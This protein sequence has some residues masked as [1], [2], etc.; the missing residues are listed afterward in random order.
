MVPDDFAALILTHQRP[1][2]QLT[3]ATLRRSGYSGAVYLIVDDEDPTLDDYR[4]K[5]G[6]SV[7]TFSKR[8]AH[9]VT[10]DADNSGSMRGVV[11]ARNAAWDIAR[12]LGLRHFIELDDD[13]THFALRF[14]AS[15]NYVNRAVRRCLDDVIVA[16]CEWLESSGA[17]SVAFSQGGD[18]IGGGNSSYNAGGPI[19]KRKAMNGFLL[20]TDRPFSFYGRINEDVNA[21]VTL[22]KVGALFFTPFQACLNQIQ[23]QAQ[24]GGLTEI[25][26]DS[27]TYYK[28]FLS[29]MWEPSCV[30][31]AVMGSPEDGQAAHYRIHHRVDWRRAVPCI[32]PHR[33][34]K[35]DE[36]T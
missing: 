21:Y 5:F 29:V 19:A 32:L 35:P 34:R 12:G 7:L 1:D 2:R 36:V 31:V 23:T 26:L 17:M 10:D 18:H 22:G 9:A 14:D 28:S 27:G 20:S 16:M 15:L 33:Y 24:S 6:D 30:Q 25:Y 3:L 8:D 11:Y 4:A 13:Y